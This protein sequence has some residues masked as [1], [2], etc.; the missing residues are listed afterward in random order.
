MR[1]LLPREHG[2]YGQIGVPLVVALAAGRPTLLSVALSL[3]AIAA[4]L[5]HEPLLYLLS[6]ATA[7]KARRLE[8]SV[9]GEIILA[10]VL[11]ALAIPVALAGGVAPI[12]AVWTWAVWA[13]GFSAVV[14]ALHAA[15]LHRANRNPL[16]AR[17]AGAAILVAAFVLVL[18]RPDPLVAA[19]P[20]VGAAVALYALSP[21]P[22]HLRPV[23][24]LLMTATVT[25]GVLLVG[26]HL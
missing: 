6:R 5:S 11:A 4:F 21:S 17:V 12:D 25:S 14:C 2:A 18:V 22:R 26:M 16:P 24:W 1:L 7:R 10:G 23:G 15:V 8:R 3:A 13:L 20:L 9:P 19:L